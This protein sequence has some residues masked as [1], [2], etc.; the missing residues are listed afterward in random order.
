MCQLLLLLSSHKFLLVTDIKG[1]PK[2]TLQAAVANKYEEGMSHNVTR[3]QV[4]QT[5]SKQ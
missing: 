5:P 2:G 4:T 1:S 3:N